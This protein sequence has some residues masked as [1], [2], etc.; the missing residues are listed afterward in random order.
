MAHPQVLPEDLDRA[1][2]DL[3]LTTIA[4]RRIIEEMELEITR[5]NDLV[6]A[7][8]EP[9]DMGLAPDPEDESSE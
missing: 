8:S 2:H 7:M 6:E 1:L 3:L 5:L 9:E 4:Q